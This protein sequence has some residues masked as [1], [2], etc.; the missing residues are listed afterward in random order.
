VHE[1][2]VTQNLLATVLQEAKSANAE[3][4]TV[5][6]LVV[7]ELSGVV[8]DCVQFYF[9]VLKM[10]TLAETAVINFKLVPSILKCRDCQSEFKPENEQWV[11][12]ECGKQ[13]VEITGGRDCF[14]E[15]ME[16]EP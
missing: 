13:S 9:D 16:V 3:K 12:P 1:L 6:Y 2:A 8:G 5:I 14:I 11:C 4:I 15:S 10:G 7:G